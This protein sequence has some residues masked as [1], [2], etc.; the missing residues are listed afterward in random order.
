M[1]PTDKV[2]AILERL[3]ERSKN[4]KVRWT[5]GGR[6]NGDGLSYVVKFPNSSL[7]IQL[8][9]P[10]AEPD[11]YEILLLD[12]IGHCADSI[13]VHEEDELFALTESLYNDAHRHVTGW[14]KV[15]ADIELGVNV[16]DVVG[17]PPLVPANRF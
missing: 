15:L 8:V 6:P 11:Y 5:T 9:T 17:L 16:P 7:A 12:A 13:V 1:I 4:D 2:R 10:V 14:D 3:A